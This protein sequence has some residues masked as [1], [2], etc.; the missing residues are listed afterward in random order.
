MN[1]CVLFRL[2]RCRTRS[3]ALG[4]SARRCVRNAVRSGVFPLVRPLP[5]I[6]S[7]ARSG[8]LFRDFAGTA[9]R[10]DFQ[11]R[12]SSPYVLRLRDAALVPKATSGSAGSL[13]RCVHACMGSSTAQGLRSARI[14]SSAVWPSVLF[15][16]VGTLD[17]EDFAAQYPAHVS[18]C[19]RFTGVLANVS[20]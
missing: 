17:I 16:A 5:S 13:T 20:A 9:G 11:G 7:A 15:H 4:A 1:R 19:Q 8:A 10:S 18:P 6:T 14:A 3:S 12:A 2:A